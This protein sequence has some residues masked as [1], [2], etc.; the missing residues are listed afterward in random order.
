MAKRDPS[1]QKIQ[2]Q[3]NGDIKGPVAPHG[4]INIY[5]GWRPLVILSL[6]VVVALSI[7]LALWMQSGSSGSATTGD[8]ATGSHPAAVTPANLKVLVDTDPFH[9]SSPDMMEVYG[10][11]QEW[12]LPAGQTV[13]GDPGIVAENF[14]KFAESY[15][16]VAVGRL[17]FGVTIQNLAGG[18]VYL[19]SMEVTNLVCGAPMKGIRI[20]EG[21]GADPLEPRAIVIDLDAKRPT[22]LYYPKTV[23]LDPALSTPKPFGFPVPGNDTVQFDIAALLMKSQRSCSFELAINAVINGESRTVP[24][25]DAGKPF[26]VVGNLNDT[27]WMYNGGGGPTTWSG[28]TVSKPGIRSPSQ[29]LT[30]TDP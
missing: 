13:V 18:D 2:S 27:F 19:R 15:H 24:I 7:A 10:R 28:G 14:Y 11:H 21:G 3:F 17:V 23:N 5:S 26:K 9:A 29:A 30:V 6:A 1:K 20:F 16:G 25:T 4:T 22:P 12:L 8:T